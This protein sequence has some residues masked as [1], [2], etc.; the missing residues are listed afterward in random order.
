L[1]LV[2]RLKFWEVV[3]FKVH[4]ID[5]AL[6][7]F[8][9]SRILDNQVAQ[10]FLLAGDSVRILQLGKIFGAEFFFEHLLDLG[11]RLAPRQRPLGQA[12]WGQ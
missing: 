9:L 6:T 4:E 1:V 7:W 8:Q 12:N 3:R 2:A 5:L 10:N 11:A